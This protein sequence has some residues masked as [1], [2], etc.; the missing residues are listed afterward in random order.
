MSKKWKDSLLDL[1]LQ[2][3]ALYNQ[4]MRG[5]SIAN[6]LHIN[7]RDSENWCTT[8]DLFGA[9]NFLTMG[10]KKMKYTY[11]TKLA[12]V[13]AVVDEGRSTPEVMLEY[14]IVSTK[15]F[16]TW[17]TIYRKQGAEG[18][19][20][21]AK[22]RPHKKDLVN[23]FTVEQKLRKQIEELQLEN[24]ILKKVLALKSF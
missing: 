3:L 1:K 10:S 4:G 14:G 19:L 22:G 11:E 12:A 13:K 18:L 21:K 7:H 6:R 23:E 16:K 17:R 8:I 2:F 15:T 20:S 5:C 9:D 24:E